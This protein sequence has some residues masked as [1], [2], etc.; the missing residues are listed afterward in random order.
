M[1]SIIDDKMAMVAGDNTPRLTQP[2]KDKI[3][4]AYTDL[5]VG[6]GAANWGRG[7]DTT[8]GA[9]WYQATGQIRAMLG[10]RDKNNAVTEYLNQVFASHSIQMSRQMMTS[11]HK[12]NTIDIPENVRA[13]FIKRANKR[14]GDAMQVINQM[15]TQYQAKNA[16]VVKPMPGANKSKF[17]MA[18]QIMLMK[19]KMGRDERAA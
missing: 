16:D 13:E 1:D 7:S 17:V 12:D 19:I 9:A 4:R 18:N 5:F 6:L 11:P 2:E 8:L 3:A 15:T 14:V 10:A